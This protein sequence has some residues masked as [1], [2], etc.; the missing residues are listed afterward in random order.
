MEAETKPKKKHSRI[1]VRVTYFSEENHENSKP[2]H[3][4]ITSDDKNPSAD[5]MGSHTEKPFKMN[6]FSVE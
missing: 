5:W 2:D 3:T 6:K 4:T 1:L